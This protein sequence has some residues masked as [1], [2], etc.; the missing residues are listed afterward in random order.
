MAMNDNMIKSCTIKDILSADKY[1]IPIY[2]RNY[3]WGEREVV[4]LLED[5]SDYV[6]RDQNYYIGSLVVYRR[7]EHTLFEIIDGQQRF[8]TLTI[9]LC[10]LKTK[11][12][13]VTD[14]LDWFSTS[15]LSYEGHEDANTV[16]RSLLQD[17]Q[18]IIDGAENI[19]D[20]YKLI[21][22]NLPKVINS[23][24]HVDM[25]SFVEYLLTRVK[26]QRIEMPQGTNLNH[27]F[28]IMNSRGEQLE[29][30]EV[31]KAQLMKRLTSTEH[32]A[33]S[34]IWEACSMMHKYVQMGFG[35]ECR[36]QLFGVDGACLNVHCFEDVVN[37]FNAKNGAPE[38]DG[39]D[40][41]KN[42]TI[43]Q[44]LE[45]AENNMQY[46]LPEDDI[47]SKDAERWGS[48][49]NFPNFLLQVLI[50]MVH[51]DSL[52]YDE[53]LLAL[54]D[55]RLLSSFDTVLRR[56]SVEEQTAF[57]RRYIYMLLRMRWLFDKYVIKR[58]RTGNGEKWS[59]EKVKVYDK[60]KVGYVSTF[61]DEDRADSSADEVRMI[62]AMFH[63][64]APTQIYKHWLNAVLTFVNQTVDETG[65]MPSQALRAY[66]WNLAKA[67]MLDQYL[68][69]DT[70]DFEQIIYDN[71]AIAVHTIEECDWNLLNEGCDVPN[72]VFNFYDYLL[73]LEHE[74]KADFEFTYRTSVEHFYPQHPEHGHR[75]LELQY[76][77]SFG[78]LCLISRGM[79]SRFG[80]NMPG[81][82]L[83]NYGTRDD[84]RSLSLKLQQMLIDVARNPSNCWEESEIE[85]AERD[86]KERI[87]RALQ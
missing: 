71:N 21:Q 50:V 84:V 80:N 75:I 61:E 33:F 64:S 59:L 2:Q 15:N 79:N 42:R 68:V 20:V 35:S 57:V 10:V 85:F 72:F 7:D 78:N 70:I 6:G 83:A 81:A 30:H 3:D 76:L 69:K 1:I 47:E 34:A 45:D 53:K 17:R 19:V 12:S 31:L 87:L 52:E 16:L 48:V 37:A 66:L 41:L 54:D 44:L 62:E 23:K 56:L 74:S 4:Q 67:Y 60:S 51:E 63:V 22:K 58:E 29:K 13:N 5:I 49:I 73:W 18:I 43:L 28:E 40:T 9:L 77:N 8:T 36:E 27:Y 11:N 82:K 38:F 14:L 24:A 39:E 55:K 32:G 86:A 65:N 26:I 25:R 46:P